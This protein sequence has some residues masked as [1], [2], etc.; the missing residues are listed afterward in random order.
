[1]SV[2]IHKTPTS[3]HSS[4]LK[5]SITKPQRHTHNKSQI[6]R[7]TYTHN[8]PGHTPQ[9]MGQNTQLTGTHSTDDGTVYTTH[10]DTLHRGWESIHNS[11]EHTPQ[12]MGQYTQLTGTH[13]TEDGTVYTSHRDTLHRGWDSIHNSPGHTPQR[14][15]QNMGSLT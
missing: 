9:R 8:S 1:M 14:M 5:P 12:R 11:P 7:H 10:R 13:S 4:S 6:H 2:L 3:K 15:G